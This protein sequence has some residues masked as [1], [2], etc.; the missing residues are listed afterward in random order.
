MIQQVSL[1]NFFWVL[2]QRRK[3]NHLDDPT[4]PREDML[5]DSK[6]MLPDP[7]WYK[8]IVRNNNKT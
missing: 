8:E 1:D 7:V 4:D 2:S 5:T 6:R 3:Q